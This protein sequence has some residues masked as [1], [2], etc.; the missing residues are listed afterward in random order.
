MT[1]AGAEGCIWMQS[2]PSVRTFDLSFVC[3]N[4]VCV[5]GCGGALLLCKGSRTLQILRGGE[6]AKKWQRDAH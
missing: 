2:F 3:M 5:C 1:Q 6:M 4:F